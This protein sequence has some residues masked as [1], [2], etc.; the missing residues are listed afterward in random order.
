MSVRIVLD[1]T[2]V[3]HL[4]E[5]RGF[6]S[7]AELAEQTARVDPKRT[8]VGPRVIWDAEN[9]KPVTAR[10]W[11]LIAQ[12]LD[13]SD[14]NE[15][16]EGSAPERRAPMRWIALATAGAIVV[17]AAAAV[18][19]MIRPRDPVVMP[20]DRTLVFED[21]RG[22]STLRHPMTLAHD[23]LCSNL[24]IGAGVT[25][26]TDG[27][28]IL[29]SRTI[30]N[31]G[32]IVTGYTRYREYPQSYGGSGGGGGASCTGSGGQDGY[33]TR[34][35]GGPGSL[36]PADGGSP[37]APV[38]TASVLE[39]WYLVGMKRYLSGAAGG[40]D[41][42]S[43]YTGTPGARGIYIQAQRIIA[44]RIVAQGQDA[45]DTSGCGP[46]HGSA[47]G[48]G[49][50]V[51]LAYGDALVPGAYYVRGGRGNRTGCY[52]SGSGGSG[53]V[54][55]YDFGRSPPVQLPQLRLLTPR[56]RSANDCAQRGRIGIVNNTGG[57]V[58]LLSGNG[59]FA[60]ISRHNKSV[61]ARPGAI[62]RG[63][64]RLRTVNRSPAVSTTPLIATPTWGKRETVWFTVAPT[65]SGGTGT[66]DS[67]VTVKVPSKDGT[68]A[69]IFAFQVASRAAF[70]ASGSDYVVGPPHWSFRDAVAD[71]D[72]AQISDAQ[73]YGCAI[74]RR[75]E[76][77]GYVWLYVPA[78][79]LRIVVAGRA[80]R[81]GS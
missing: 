21:L 46:I 41:L 62:L 7:Q 16:L 65:V 72:E 3:R 77:P 74:A 1:K 53:R 69:L 71:Y 43:R 50:I 34:V 27:H 39:S 31:R 67:A 75:F 35:P 45:C 14:P 56:V 60:S 9:G 4:R 10:T 6:S 2:K 33:A 80:A 12:A 44:G 47:G 51:V 52:P 5:Q 18:L 23:L 68:Y 30:D 55:A 70:V 26:A 40:G 11:R 76:G 38:L 15:L 20:A 19:S 17:I 25:L 59:A 81:A 32:T 79:A 66:Y 48:G 42:A 73:T 54:I 24:T 8:G 29:C 36:A 49:G 63:S 58:A 78:D 13:I 64:I 22:E 37:P 28:S 57:T 61:A